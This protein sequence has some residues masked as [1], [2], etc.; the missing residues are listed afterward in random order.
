MERLPI[1]GNVKII[2]ETCSLKEADPSIVSRMGLVYMDDKCLGWGPLADA[3]L[4][5]RPTQLVHIL[6]RA[7]TKVLDPVLV[8]MEQEA[9]PCLKLSEN[10][11]FSS[12]LSLLTALLQEHTDL[13]GDLHVERLFIFSLI[14]TFG[15]LLTREIDQK[16]FS[17][18]LLAVSTAYV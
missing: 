9:R 15:G 18:L 11:L 5:G 16:N 7:F 1:T 17:Q 10:V 6:Q 14:W 4:A 13:G 3:W 12:C 8:F 2:F